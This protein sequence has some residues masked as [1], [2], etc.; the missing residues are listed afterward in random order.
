MITLSAG[1]LTLSVAYIRDLAPRPGAG[2]LWMLYSAWGLFALALSTILAAFLSS[3]HAW[4][5]ALEREDQAF[6]VTEP[7]AAAGN[8][9]AT[10]AHCCNWLCLVFFVSGVLCFVLFATLNFNGREFV[11]NPTDRN[12]TPPGTESKSSVPPKNVLPRPAS[13]PPKNVL[14]SSPVSPGQPPKQ[15]GQK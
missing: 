5:R 1:A 15:G 4:R 9:W 12:V 3:Q 2:T 13:V 8:C 10:A 14:P 6:K 7:P 11:A